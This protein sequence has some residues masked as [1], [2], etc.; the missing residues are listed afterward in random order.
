MPNVISSQHHKLN[1]ISH[2]H[3]RIFSRFCAIKPNFRGL[4]N[5]GK[6]LGKINRNKIVSNS[7]VLILGQDGDYTR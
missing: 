1:L 4:H 6:L 3:I 7:A 2:N 5:I